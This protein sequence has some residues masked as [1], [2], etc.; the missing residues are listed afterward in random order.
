MKKFLSYFFLLSSSFLIFTLTSCS[1]LESKSSGTD[2]AISKEN[3]PKTELQKF[4]DSKGS[5]RVAVIKFYAD[6]C[7]TCRDY[8]PQYA[9]AK[10]S[11]KDANVDFYEVNV[12]QKEYSALIK[13]LKVGLIPI[14]Y[15]VS[16]DKKSIENRVGYIS[17]GQLSE[18]VQSLNLK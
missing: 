10:A 8:Q 1:S 2:T 5:K 16:Q 11:L 17:S 13:E 12:D 18:K 6:W 9:A 3:H 14:T 4:L 15:F 7:G